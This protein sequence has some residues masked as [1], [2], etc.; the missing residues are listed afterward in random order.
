MTTH[1]PDERP[2]IGAELVNAIK[3]TPVVLVLDTSASMEHNNRIGILNETLVEFVKMVQTSDELSD[4]L[5]LCIVTFGGEAKV[6][7]PWAS[8]DEI[9]F[10][11]L[12]ANGGTPMGDAVTLAI[13]EL[14][15]LRGELQQAGTPYNVPWLILMSDGEPTDHWEEA[16][17]LVQERIAAVKLVPFAFGIPPSKDDILRRFIPKGFPVYSVREQD[18]KPLFVKWLTGSLVKVAES[19][20]GQAGGLQLSAPPAIPV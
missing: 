2:R 14:D 1:Q 13:G 7:A 4:A 20:P 16:A 19:S 9:H 12:E 15:L 8:V 5:L 3:R 18:I 10:E 17:E 11:A 6:A